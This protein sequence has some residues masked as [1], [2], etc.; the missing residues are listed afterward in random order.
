MRHGKRW[1]TH[2]TKPGAAKVSLI[3]RFTIPEGERRRLNPA[4]NALQMYHSTL[5]ATEPNLR[6]YVVVSVHP[7]RF[8]PLLEGTGFQRMS[9]CDFV[10]DG[11][12][13][14]CFV[15]DWQ[16]EPLAGLRDRQLRMPPAHL[17]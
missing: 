4:M 3:S 9:G 10:I 5:C 1:A 8:A 15:H 14:G 16:T 13:I 2:F 12:P 7:D 6:F 11:L 17:R